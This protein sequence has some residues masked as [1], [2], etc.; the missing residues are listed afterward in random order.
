MSTPNSAPVSSNGES[1]ELSELLKN[2]FSTIEYLSERFKDELKNHLATEN[3]QADEGEKTILL[4]LS[5]EIAE[6]KNKEDLTE[7]VHSKL[8]TFFK[9]NGLTIIL[10]NN[11][12]QT[13]QIYMF[14]QEIR[15]MFRN[16]VTNEKNSFDYSEL[17]PLLDKLTT[18]DAH[19]EVFYDT[20]E[21]I[22]RDPG[23]N[24]F[25]HWFEKGWEK[26]AVVSLKM[27]EESLGY[28]LLH[29]EKLSMGN[30]RS[31]LLKGIS[32]QFSVALS[33]INKMDEA[34]RRKNEMELLLSINTGIASL[35]NI[36]ELAKFIKDRFKKL[37][38]CS[39]T[40]I[41]V[42]NEDGLTFNA[43]LLDED[44]REK[45]QPVYLDLKNSSHIVND[46]VLSKTM[47]TEIPLI[48]DLEELSK[49]KNPPLYIK[50]NKD[51]KQQVLLTIRLAKGDEVVGFWL[52]YFKNKDT[53][54]AEK[55]KFIQSLSHQL[56]ISVAN[57]LANQEIKSREDEKSRLL[58]FS[59]AIAPLRDKELLSDMLKIQ[60][61]ELF[62]ISDFV[63]YLLSV[64][65]LK[66]LPFLYDHDSDFSRDP[67][68]IKGLD[69]WTDLPDNFRAL[70]YA[71]D[72]PSLSE[73]RCERIHQSQNK[74]SERDS[75]VSRY[76]MLI[77]LGIDGNAVI[78]FAHPDFKQLKSKEE[79]LKSICSQ[80]S[81]ALSN[82]MANEKVNRQL[83]EIDRYKKQLEEETV[84][85][86][87]EIEVN[88]NYAEIIGESAAMQK[89]FRLV[90]QVASSDSTV[91]ILGETGT[92][93]ELIAR[94]IH[95]NSP[96]KNK[97]MVKVNCAALPANLIES[98]LFGHEKG[99]FTGA[100]ERRIGKFELANN[101][102]L[103]L[104][105]IGEMP[106]ELQ[107]KLLR[108]LQ[109]REIER[110]GGRGT[111][112]VDVRIIAATNRE[113][114]KEVDE[115]RFRSDLYYRLNIFPIYLSALRER[116]EDIPML[117]THFINRY[118]KKTGR[119]IDTIG[120]KAMQDMIQYRWPGNIRELEHLIER[121]ILLSSGNTLKQ[122]HLP[123]GRPGNI[124]AVSTSEI[125]LK[126]I[127]ENECEHILRIL[128][129][130]N[131]RKSGPGGA[132]DILGVPPSTL[133]SKIKRLGI[134]KEHLV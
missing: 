53:I 42:C 99:S 107:V 120:N 90:A 95:N 122:I 105:E 37:L 18:I 41:A 123:S 131:G 116:K 61:C 73:L 76:G 3:F 127:D 97:L 44:A 68:F 64:D 40:M 13:Y 79:L 33:N 32:S 119:Q 114:E 21:Y 117:A 129:Y 1:K 75:N 94:A 100:T 102:T 67:E 74:T 72:S 86:K 58:K 78:S 27:G 20:S 83:I 91:L 11:D 26:F 92:G 80:I 106:L 17:K 10:P 51:L 6:A 70:I 60:L 81:V 55:L 54:T 50:I 101:G 118:S 52:I 30:L 29:F 56:C 9:I 59:N 69:T 89:T 104:D 77:N 46:T 121:S 130:C 5:N 132:A 82:I 8:K 112:K 39:H 12:Q 34:L 2:H 110:V 111:I 62:N 65:R 35:R 25:K 103:F 134:K 126:T 124:S 63:I 98:E 84:Y 31:N 109:E 14:P 45:A 15:K 16:T 28:I 49:Q 38:G 87:E 96:R 4:D 47:Q 85:L 71:I 43:F 113:L 125:L 66:F 57:I 133:N 115:G 48:F 93:K 23:T 7:A 22:D 108:A 128:K 88:Q 36:E 19:V 24:Y